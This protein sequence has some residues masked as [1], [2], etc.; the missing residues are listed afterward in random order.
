[1][2]TKTKAQQ[3]KYR[4]H[5]VYQANWNALQT[6]QTNEIAAFSRP[7]RVL[8]PKWKLLRVFLT[9]GDEMVFFCRLKENGKPNA[10]NKQK[11]ITYTSKQNNRM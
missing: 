3:K 5:T 2:T 6:K 4:I 9:N 7:F 1:M 10:Q 11:Q 8:L